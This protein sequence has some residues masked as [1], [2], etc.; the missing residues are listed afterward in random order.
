MKKRFQKPVI[1]ILVSALAAN[2]FLMGSSAA[3]FA[4]EET[5]YEEFLEGSGDWFEEEYSEEGGEVSG[6]NEDVIFFEEEIPYD[7]ANA[8]T[9]EEGGLRAKA[10]PE[11]SWILP[12]GTIMRVT[13][14]TEASQTYSYAGCLSLLNAQKSEDS[15]DYTADN[16]ELFDLQFLKHREDEEGNWVVRGEDEE[17]SPLDF[18]ADGVVYRMEE[19]KPEGGMD[20]T[21]TFLEMDPMTEL[22]FHT[23]KG[24]ICAMK[25]SDDSSVVLLDRYEIPENVQEEV[26]EESSPESESIPEDVILFSEE[27]LDENLNSEDELSETTD[28]EEMSSENANSEDEASDN[29]DSEETFSGNTDSEEMASEDPESRDSE[30]LSS[31]ESAEPG[32]DAA[33][34]SFLVVT[35]EETTIPDPSAESV[36]EPTPEPTEE[37]TPQPTEEPTPEPTEE[38]T[39]KPTEAPTPEPTEEPTPEPTEAPTPEPTEEPTPEPTKVLTPEPTEEPTK[40]PA[41]ESVEAPAPVLTEEPTPGPTLP[42]AA[43]V[44]PVTEEELLEWVDSVPDGQGTIEPLPTSEPAQE[45]EPSPTE[46]PAQSEEAPAPTPESAKEQTAAAPLQTVTPTP[47]PAQEAV[48]DG[49]A[50]IY[51]NLNLVGR[52]IEED[53]EFTFS[54]IAD[55]STDTGGSSVATPMPVS[56]YVT[57][58]NADALSF[59]SIHFTKPG[60]YNYLVMENV[61]SGAAFNNEGK[62]EKD[63]VVYD[64]TQHKVQI[65]V[66]EAGDNKLSA[67]VYYDDVETGT[68]TFTN[69]YTPNTPTIAAREITPTAELTS[70]PAQTEARTSLVS[71]RSMTVY[72]TLLAIGAIALVALLVLLKLKN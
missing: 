33:P 21:V 60:T 23:D 49:S 62:Y 54:L 22:S 47:A 66:E 31:E 6:E 34:E 55:S 42:A 56:S 40:A 64:S 39:P 5:D 13:P 69:M 44:V 70:T 58:K 1:R 27:T 48:M 2:V 8:L 30:A 41:P 63:G 38:P 36:Q 53:D 4:H 50:E 20:L 19:V 59:G 51:V 65:R 28:S 10:V 46:E 68:L 37:P 11:Y 43:E 26:P 9:W 57:A 35:S 45:A 52:S 15:E 71:G 67:Q 14:V 18:A 61:P 12:S 25:D 3:C 32:V 29:A 17:P 24:G 72:I 16:T 7:E